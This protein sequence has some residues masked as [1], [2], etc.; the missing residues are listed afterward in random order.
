MSITPNEINTMRPYIEEAKGNILVLGL[1]LGYYPFTISL[2]DEVK[3]ITIVELD[4]NIINIFNKHLLPLFPHKEKIQIIKGEAIKFLNNNKDHYDFVFVDLWHNPEDGLPLYLR[5]SKI[6]MH[7][8]NC[9]FQY[10]LEKSLIALY[11]RCLLTIYEEALQGYDDKAYLEAVHPIDKIINEIYFKTK[12]ITINN[13]DDI[14]NL[15]TD[16]SILKLIKS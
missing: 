2:K 11:R 10:W 6:A 4:Q 13:Y 8:K 14:N 9:K 5:I 7:Y 1:G 12:N 16:E 15:L 3:K